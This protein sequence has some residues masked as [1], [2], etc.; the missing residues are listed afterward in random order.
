MKEN[1][2]SQIK[3]IKN[4]NKIK[5]FYVHTNTDLTEGRGKEYVLHVCQIE[6]TA[7][8]LGKGNY[9]QGMNC[10]V[11]EGYI[12]FRDGTWWQRLSYVVPPTD[13]DTAVETKE[14]QKRDLIKRMQDA[15]FSD[16]DI[17]AI[18]S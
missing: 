4:D 18:K 14:T 16:E 17:S 8:R 3:R 12:E 5:V 2:Y 10:P 7:H 15:G 11:R 9:V 1:Y 6:T 13:E